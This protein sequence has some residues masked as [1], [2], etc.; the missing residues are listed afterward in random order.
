MNTGS[1]NNELFESLDIVII[2]AMGEPIKVII[3]IKT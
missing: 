3:P 2:K 1:N